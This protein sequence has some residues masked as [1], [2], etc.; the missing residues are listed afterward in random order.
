MTPLE[1]FR[2]NWKQMTITKISPQSASQIPNLDQGGK[3]DNSSFPQVSKQI[4]G[5]NQDMFNYGKTILR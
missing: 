4:T 5:F 2:L 3:S 1:H